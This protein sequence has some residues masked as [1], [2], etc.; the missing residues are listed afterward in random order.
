MKSLTESMKNLVEALEKVQIDDCSREFETTLNNLIDKS[1]KILNDIETSRHYRKRSSTNASSS[2]DDVRCISNE[3]EVIEIDS[4]DDGDGKSSKRLNVAEQDGDLEN[5]S[6]GS[7]VIP[8]IT[9]K[10]GDL[11]KSSRSN[12]TSKIIQSST[13]AVQSSQKKSVSQNRVMQPDLKLKRLNPN[14][15]CKKRCVVKLQRINLETLAIHGLDRD[16]AT[17]NKDNDATLDRNVGSANS[18]NNSTLSRN[19]EKKKS[20]TKVSPTEN[21][22]STDVDSKLMKHYTYDDYRRRY[23][24]VCLIQ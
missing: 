4:E 2:S 10:D 21:K 13:K 19:E 5:S 15:L 6:N 20:S 22:S 9:E 7:N 12:V 18:H 1:K 17:A 11:G 8:K 23:Q 24:D 16:V 3:V 14:E